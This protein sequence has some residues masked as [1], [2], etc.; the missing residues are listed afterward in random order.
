MGVFTELVSIV[1]TTM[2][3]DEVEFMQTGVFVNI[4]VTLC[5]QYRARYAQ[6]ALENLAEAADNMQKVQG[7]WL[8]ASYSVSRNVWV[9]RTLDGRH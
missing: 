7:G 1:V 5:V 2:A 4:I 9:A 3:N 8:R 6:K